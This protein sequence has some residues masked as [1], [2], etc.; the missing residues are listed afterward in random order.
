MQEEIDA[1]ERN[2][3]WKVVPR[4]PDMFVIDGKWVHKEKFDKSGNLCRLKARWVARGFRQRA[5]TQS[6]LRPSEWKAFRLV[7]ALAAQKGWKLTSSDVNNVR[8]S[9]RPTG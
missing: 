6:F 7:I 3:T 8:F 1:L 2:N 5:S 4:T 9:T